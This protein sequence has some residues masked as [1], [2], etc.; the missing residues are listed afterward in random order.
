MKAAGLDV[1]VVWWFL[2]LMDSVGQSIGQFMNF[3]KDDFEADWTKVAEGRLTQVYEV[4]L[5]VWRV[6]CALKSYDT[7]ICPSKFYRWDENTEQDLPTVI[8]VSCTV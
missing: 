5:K 3:K 6:K 1:V 2:V 8:S 7:T 4:K